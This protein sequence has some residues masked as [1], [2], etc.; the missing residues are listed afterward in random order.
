[1]PGRAL[2]LAAVACAAGLVGLPLTLLLAVTVL[3][4][5]TDTP[6][7]TPGG[8]LRT[9]AVPDT[10]QNWIIRA[11]AGDDRCP[12]LSPALLAAQLAQESGFNPRAVS[13]AGAQGI[14]QFM[15]GTWPTWAIDADGNGVASPF[16]P[17]DAI[18]AQ[19]RFLCALLADT[20]AG[21][22]DGTLTGDPVSLALA[23]YNCGLGCVRAAGGL[24]AIGETRDYVTRITAAVADYT[25]P[26]PPPAGGGFGERVAAAAQA[27]TDTPYVWG[28]G[29]EFGP[30][31]GT[32]TGTAGFDCSGLTLYAV[33]QASGG[34]IRLPHYTGDQ[35]QQGT[36]VAGDDIHPGD[37]IF[38]HIDGPLSHV[39]IALGN[40]QMI[41]APRT[42]KTV[43]TVAWT[44]DPYWT[45]HY[46][47]TRR[48]TPNEP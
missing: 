30:T 14:A 37:L 4:D 26:T 45:D 12:Q 20:T 34:T 29:N 35:Y 6:T 44:T 3:H 23:A 38:F 16:D 32:D 42:G 13:A 43:E 28:G 21:I 11:G 8:P 1:M 31:T 40:G 5:R 48:I 9:T 27:W 2:A 25:A 41:H 22:A 33:Y 47:G 7:A 36:P 24:P 46:A 18:T 19:G 39:A 15:P 10:Y 17:A